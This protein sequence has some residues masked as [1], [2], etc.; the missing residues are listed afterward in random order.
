[1]S[2]EVSL[3]E[4]ELGREGLLIAV[5]AN[6]DRLEVALAQLIDGS[7]RAGRTLQAASNWI[8]R[9]SLARAARIDVTNLSKVT[10]P[11][12]AAGWLHVRSVE[13]GLV[14]RRGSV[15]DVLV[16]GRTLDLWRK[17]IGAPKRK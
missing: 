8:K 17:G 16:G 12:V 4:S 9:A 15:V 3:S 1:M 2:D 11:L 10:A 14:F 5:M 13:G 6:R 7:P